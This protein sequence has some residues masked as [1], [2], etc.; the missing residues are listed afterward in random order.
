MP[1][2]LALNVTTTGV[3]LA[4]RMLSAFAQGMEEASVAASRAGGNF[5]NLAG[6]FTGM[7]VAKHI[8]GLMQSMLKPAIDME[9]SLTQLSMITGESGAALI[10]YKE[11]ALEAARATSFNP[12]E[13]IAALIRLRQA[14]GDTQSA[15]A[16]LTPTLTLAM[17]S[18]GKVSPEKAGEATG[19][20]V[21]AFGMNSTEAARALQELGA[22]GRITGLQLQ[23]ITGVM[24]KLNL[25]S[26]QSQ[27]TFKETVLAFGLARRSM[28]SSERGATQ[29][30]RAIQDLM[31]GTSF[32]D[33]KH[34]GLGPLGVETMDF[35]TGKIRSLGD[36]MG[37][38]ASKS[39]GNL[40]MAISQLQ[41]SGGS[42]GMQAMMALMQQLQKGIPGYTERG[43]AL[44]QRLLKEIDKQASQDPLGKMAAKYKESMQFATQQISEGFIRIKIAIG[45]SMLQPLKQ[46]A[47]VVG[48]LVDGTS[49]FMATGVG[50]FMSTFAGRLALVAAGAFALKAVFMG[51][52]LIVL[53]TKNNVAAFTSAIGSAFLAAGSGAAGIG[54]GI[55]QRYAT[56]KS[57]ALAASLGGTAGFAGRM[58]P[59]LGTVSGPLT[60][61][62]A[63]LVNAGGGSLGTMG[64][65]GA[66]ARTFGGTLLA[67]AK[68]L[69]SFIGPLGIATA[70][71]MFLPEAISWVSSKMRK[72]AEGSMSK[73]LGADWQKNILKY[74]DEQLER[75]FGIA[76]ATSGKD[77]REEVYV[78]RAIAQVNKTAADAQLLAGN[79][80]KQAAEKSYYGMQLGSD[81]YQKVVDRLQSIFQTERKPVNMATFRAGE[82]A[83]AGMGK[84]G[85]APG[86]EQHMAAMAALREMSM[87]RGLVE[88]GKRRPLSSAEGLRLHAATGNAQ[89]MMD[90]IGFETG[91]Q[92]LF[93]LAQKFRKEVTDP[94]GQSL[95]KANVDRTNQERSLI[96]GRIDPNTG[97]PI[98]AG[99][100]KA[101]TDVYNAETARIQRDTRVARDRIAVSTMAKVASIES[102]M[103]GLADAIT[104]GV[105]LG[106]G[107]N[108]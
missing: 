65:V 80:Q 58:T 13:S 102:Y 7:V 23:D 47:G 96:Y 1:P 61:T 53:A 26:F 100:E 27:S 90:K 54:G 34:F 15:L 20:L 98:A 89:L 55:G 60:A 41:S 39:G 107:G 5:K 75:A 59:G 33:K 14:T 36:I 40:N 11:A 57:A 31:S 22:T 71:L 104:K 4:T 8:G 52:S 30:M 38:V 101:A 73:T 35:Y 44:W 81:A 93:A 3:P 48:Y 16:L 56:N 9:T 94:I 79:T 70:A 49:K 63:A 72:S 85:F 64:T 88:T 92:G 46:V 21:K 77:I 45:E 91:N 78:A 17:A 83:I 95:S 103:S 25:A 32:G 82:S 43:I 106:M 105:R 28:H 66:A 50:Q 69:L 68:G 24:T 62:Q 87:A 12:T 84:M 99:M 6:A 42:A 10:K 86:S 76:W 37:Q 18:A 51:I 19:A 97:K 74:T 29:V 108:G 67:G 2:N